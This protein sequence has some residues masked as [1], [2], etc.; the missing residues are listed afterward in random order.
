MRRHWI[1]VRVIMLALLHAASTAFA[2][3]SSDLL[4]GYL[5][6]QWRAEDGAPPDIR[7]MAQGVDGW[8][9]LGT[10][11]GLYRFDGVQFERMTGILEN[12][13]IHELY[14]AP[15]G[16]L[17]VGLRAEG[18]AIVHPDG[19][20][21]TMPGSDGPT[22]GTISSMAMDKD[23]SLWAVGNAVYRW[24]AGKWEMVDDDKVW[25]TSDM[26]SLALDDAGD[27]WI[28]H[29]GGIRRFD[30]ATAR[31]VDV[32]H[33]GGGSLTI[34]PD[35]SVWL[36]PNTGQQVRR[37]SPPRGKL[38]R[39]DRFNPSGSRFAGMFDASG[40]LWKLR[41]PE[42]ICVAAYREGQSVIPAFDK[43]LATAPQLS[44]ANTRQILEDREG[45][46]WVATQ[47]GLDRFRS[48]RL[49]RVALPNSENGM[50]MAADAE[51]RTWV[52]DGDSGT[53]WQI[54]P[55]G[56]AQ[57]VSGPPVTLVV[58]DHEGGILIA[59]R[60]TIWRQS[61]GV[62]SE[63]PLP[64]GPDGKPVDRRLFA[65]IDDGKI[66]W[67]AA[68]D[69][70]LI[71]WIDGK[72]RPSTEFNLDDKLYL[73]TPGARG[74]LW[75]ARAGGELLHYDNNKLVR[76]D[77]AAAGLITGIF[78]GK[79]LIV[80]GDGGVGVLR[81]G[82]L[83]MLHA[84]NP[85]ILRGISGLV[86]LPNGDCWLNG[87]AGV[88]HVLADDW[89][90]ALANPAVRL[91]YEL[92]DATDG[93]PGRA[94][95]ERSLSSAHSGDGHVVWFIGTEGVVFLDTR[96]LRRNRVRPV[97]SIQSV[98]T[99]RG[100]SRAST[101]LLGAGTR[102]FSV[103]FTAPALRLPERV[104][105]EYRLDG[106]DSHWQDAGFRRAASYTNVPAGDYTFR[107]RAIN[108]DGLRSASEATL[109]IRI[110][111]T[112]VQRGWFQALA[113]ALL[114]LS[115]VA[116]YR[117]RIR[118]VTRRLVERL[119]VRTAERERIARAM[120]DSFL[121]SLFALLMRIEAVTQLLPKNTAVSAE[122]E[123][124]R[125][126]ARTAIARGRDQVAELRAGDNVDLGA[127][128][129]TSVQEV[130]P[131]ADG[132]DISLLVDGAP[133]PMDIG[134]A[135]EINDI[136]REALRN[137][138]YHASASSITVSLHYGKRAF[139]LSVVDNGRGIDDATLQAGGREGHW[140]LTGMRERAAK[141]GGRLTSASEQS[142]GTTIALH[143]PAKRAYRA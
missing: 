46:I 107:V 31:F 95:I 123:T 71:A 14:A 108:E 98:A 81:Q 74:E 23:G 19:R 56:E 49:R 1:V 79:E 44:G 63:I 51:G 58:P 82:R 117:Y 42:P 27:I 114:A 43:Q 2:A 119:E 134:M 28:A 143:V 126:Q 84:D 132:P 80:A 125:Q 26:R 50:T 59:G 115:L 24:R 45:N 76:H 65:L 64:P 16:D 116:M 101:A 106:F 62:R 88:I 33:D 120:H 137:A 70:S 69:T 20:V 66:V 83:Q 103:N 48:A 92:F 41:C 68:A 109:P 29:D 89:R 87:A 128:L 142:A 121:Q 122:L 131:P 55:E 73:L 6:S 75:I 94:L 129:A 133:R 18:L 35:G 13:R 99:E 140:G 138:V 67:A 111:P 11:G 139:S 86:I 72:W 52:A 9:W 112:L 104:R 3:P 97:P 105:F 36:L 8:L 96:T 22:L 93:Y 118:S 100:I 4:G 113:C 34:A 5:H 39:N 40:A 124:I 60:R 127:M 32:D 53:L 91:R 110:E 10:S 21:E 102:R 15:T 25:K 7:S 17:Y 38:A 37:I 57:A 90:R 77:A 30:R 136:A 78:P 12:A 135:D 61:H 130:R 47:R 141:I 54:S 85:N